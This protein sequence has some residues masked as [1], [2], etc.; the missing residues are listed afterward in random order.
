[1]SS[2]FETDIKIEIDGKEYHAKKPGMMIIEVA[3]EAGGAH[4]PRFCYHKK[5]SI[6][7][8]CRMCLVEV[9]TVGKP[10]PACAT[11]ISD[12]MRVFTKSSKALAA[13]KAV[14]EFLLINHPLDCPICDQ[15]GECELQDLSMGYG[16]DISRFNLGKRVVDDKDI[17]SL[18]MTDMTRCIHCTRCVRFGDEI[19]GMRELGVLQRGGSMEIGTY[20]EHSMRSELSGNVIELCPVGALTSK[21]YRFTARAWELDQ[22]ASIAPHDCL[23]S[24]VYVHTRRHKVMRIVPRENEAI[25]EVWLSDRDRFSYTAFNSSDRL[26]QPRIKREGQWQEVDWE[27]AL[28][29]AVTRLQEN[30]KQHGAHKV[31][32]LASASAT[33]EELFLL[34]KIMRNLGSHNVD[35]RLHQVNCADQAQSGLFPGI[36]LPIADIE[37]QQAILLIGS[38]IRREQPLLGARIRKAWLHEASIMTIN[39]VDYDKTFETEHN[40]VCH[41][42][43]FIQQLASVAKALAE[44]N[45][46][47]LPENAK[48]LLADIEIN[49]TQRAIAHKLLNTEHSVILVGASAQNHPQAATIRSLVQLIMHLSA[50]RGG[51]LT[52]GCNSAGAWLAGAIPHRA[53]C[54]HNV[55]NTGLTAHQALQQRLPA[56]ILLGVEPELDA[57]DPAVAMDS[58]MNADFVLSLS[59]YSSAALLQYADV[60][61]PITPFTETSGTY[62]NVAGEWQSFEGCVKPYAESRPAWKVLRVLGNFLNLAGFDFESSIEIRDMLRALLKERRTEQPAWYWPES[63]TC[64]IATD[65]LY[66]I[67]DWAIYSI[68]STVRRS[69]PL[70][71]SATQNTNAIII[72]SALARRFDIKQGQPLTIEQQ[73][74]VQLPV[75]INDAVPNN[76]LYIPAGSSQI[77]ALGAMY[78]PV[79][80]KQIGE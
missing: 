16:D 48:Q 36:N 26:A 56:Y 79:K 12:G 5:L 38:D 45:A 10:V 60:I 74:I 14:M 41:P 23:G 43:A 37:N 73:T 31:A 2:D 61:L 22:K 59:A 49:E 50:S 71:S 51:L 15:G 6:A 57:A 58:L 76:T 4:I 20:I 9:E 75:I 64:D 70:Q 25:N 30:I 44:I 54:G 66:R 80:I 35:H 55:S 40:I 18:V 33:L 34:Q 7:A 42:G 63:L 77:T 39:M 53:E 62:V 1:M 68:D 21:P 8:N 19:A 32:A 29:F 67:S 28:D 3:D 65:N 11:P 17:G 78:A 47:N 72:N 52:E 69:L 13:Q 24:N 46:N 27:T